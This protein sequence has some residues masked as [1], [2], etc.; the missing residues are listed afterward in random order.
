MPQA[1]KVFISF[2][3]DGDDHVDAVLA[4]ADWLRSHA[5]D[6][7]IDQYEESPPEGW[8]IW[9]QQQIE[10]A[11]FVLVVCTQAYKTRIEKNEEPGVGLGAIWEGQLIMMNLYKSQGRNSKYIPVMINPSDQAFI[12]PLLNSV[13]RYCV[14]T[15]D[16]Y[17]KLY[18]RLTAQHAIEK[19]PLGERQ[20]LPQ[21][22][23]RSRPIERRLDQASNVDIVSSTTFSFSHPGVPVN[24]VRHDNYLKTIAKT[25]TASNKIHVVAVEG[26]EGIGKTTLLGQFSRWKSD[27]CIS[28]F[29]EQ[30][31]R[32]TYDTDAMRLNI[33]RQA[34]WILNNE[35]FPQ[36]NISQEGFQEYLDR[37]HAVTRRRHAFTYF[38]LDGIDELMV[39]NAGAARRVVD[40]LP[41]PALGTS[42]YVVSGDAEELRSLFP[43]GVATK[44]FPLA[45][46]DLDETITLF[47]S[48][49][50]DLSA[51]KDLHGLCSGNPA[52]LSSARRMIVRGAKPTDLV[53]AISRVTSP[54]EVEWSV[55]ARG[56]EQI[57]RILAI[58]AFQ[59]RRSKLV[60]LTSSVGISR[61]ELREKLLSFSVI[62]VNSEDLVRFRADWFRKQAQKELHQFR[63]SVHKSIAQKL[64]SQS[65]AVDRVLDVSLHYAEAED[66]EHVLTFLSSDHLVELI[67]KA[68]S[69]NRVQNAVQLGLNAARHLERPGDQLRFGLDSAVLNEFF[70]FGYALSEVSALAAL[71]EYEAALGIARSAVMKED[72]LHLLA[73][74]ARSKAQNGDRP[75]PEL[76]EHLTALAAE[77][78]PKPLG[79][80]LSDICVELSAV[81]PDIALDLADRSQPNAADRDRLFA[82]LS[83][84]AFTVGESQ[85]STLFERMKAR[86]HKGHIDLMQNAL[87]AIAG[88]RSADDVLASARRLDKARDQ[89]FVL[90]A[91]LRSG[92]HIDDSGQII[93]YA[94]NAAITATDYTINATVLRELSE[95]LR[96][97]NDMSTSRRLIDIFGAQRGA[98]QKL[99]PTVD[100]VRLE[101]LLAETEARYDLPS[102]ETRI[103]TSYYEII[104]IVDVD[105]RTLSWAWL[106]AGLKRITSVIGPTSL[107]SLLSDAVGELEDSYLLLLDSTADH[108]QAATDIIVTIADWDVPKA[109]EFTSM[110]NTER[111]HDW[112]LLDVIE[113]IMSATA[114]PEAASFIR[115]VI[116]EIGDSELA[117]RGISEAMV[118]LSQN[119]TPTSSHLVHFSWLLQ[120]SRQIKDA[121]LRTRT[122]QAAY[123]VMCSR[124]EIDGRSL[125]ELAD[126]LLQS[127]TA[128]STAWFQV[129]DGFFIAQVLAAKAPE[130]AKEYVRR[131]QAVRREVGGLT[132][133]AAAAVYTHV[134]RLAIR[135]FSGLVRRS[136]T[137]MSDISLLAAQIDRLPSPGERAILW[138]EVAIKCACQGSAEMCREIVNERVRTVLAGISEAD[139]AYSAYVKARVS[140]AVFAS[141]TAAAYIVFTELN[142]TLRDYACF[143]TINFLLRNCLPTDPEEYLQGSGY[144]TTFT[145]LSQVC[146]V[147][148]HVSSDAFVFLVIERVVDSVTGRRN[149]A[150]LKQSQKEEIMR[151]L[152]ELAYSKFPSAKF[153]KHD[154]YKVI[155]K[156]QLNRFRFETP[157]EELVAEAHS[158]PNAADRGYVLFD[159]GL[160]VYKSDCG[161]GQSIIDSSLALIR[162]IPSRLE[163]ADRLV[164]F[165]DDL[166]LH[167]TV[168]SQNL[169]REARTTLQHSEKG[170]E[171]HSVRNLIDVAAKIGDE[172]AREL[173]SVL[174]DDHAKQMAQQRIELRSVKQQIIND[175]SVSDSVQG[176][177]PHEYSALGKM[178]LASL[179]SGRIDSIRVSSA[180]NF[181]DTLAHETLSR[182]YMLMTWIVENA[183]ERH[184][185][186]ERASIYLRPLFE[187]TIAS[188]ELAAKLAEEAFSR[189]RRK[190]SAPPS[191]SMIEAQTLVTRDQLIAY[192]KRWIGAVGGGETL[193]IVD[194][195]FTPS[196]LIFVR[197]IRSVDPGS[198]I[199]IVTS[200]NSQPSES[201]DL[202]Q[203]YAQHWRDQISEQKPP[204]TRIAFLDAANGRS[205]FP[206]TMMLTN[207][208]GVVL[209]SSLLR[210][211]VEQ[212]DSIR[213]LEPGEAGSIWESINSY[214]AGDVDEFEGSRVEYSL[215]R[216]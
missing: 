33:T 185:R 74:I 13:T 86:G 159:I 9:M 18:R 31:D 120:R 171:M 207:A 115:D 162:T 88:K 78:D 27:S 191:I 215:F 14:D 8:L 52:Y 141:D 192:L 206:R 65:D 136:L 172:F 118:E 51:L 111:R 196:D 81:L 178:L 61:D 164:Q 80:R 116:S 104:Q 57:E 76:L 154:G 208:A 94:L 126:D 26:V 213:E 2:S 62:A 163:R 72:R 97:I 182:S 24:E 91:W 148:Q 179:N 128:I 176:A 50:T 216:L 32:T 123:S 158:I 30:D 122:L 125:S 180:M 137:A 119:E 99:G 20:Q 211:G 145:K 46:F 49:M 53:K 205:P 70:R 108:Y 131:S 201:A 174:D 59:D 199:L 167:S 25:L 184:A 54:F 152:S 187:G 183:V 45:E 146:D 109:I 98:A 34:H 155:A 210:F 181:M 161:K 193:M 190:V 60:D 194:P 175:T 195:M 63:R 102:S 58:L 197:L 28:V 214:I 19:P 149:D 157:I 143:L 35:P 4:L 100:Y 110:V 168:L 209:S 85:S 75:E 48:I 71:K 127:W 106:I 83:A 165:A 202:K 150:R 204:N 90:R 95:G 103:L 132:S 134:V 124:S 23:R 92:N 156:I 1:P 3:H 166:R 189:D 77:I 21:R 16:G 186:D 36:S 84:T 188:A 107:D 96:H 200:R 22:N 39:H 139:S 117:D 40:L 169:L 55:Q 17:D 37:L 147:L 114:T 10:S 153:I 67:Q 129:E 64:L 43:T 135:A 11:Q 42:K 69:I 47:S 79:R 112:I 101:V 173:A 89:L 73:I 151:R 142:P 177:S 7:S 56:D 198:R 44:S 138:A 121:R 144:E 82:R 87:S 130:M 93:D 29:I 15:E 160:F 68:Q 6:A 203:L 133:R 113:R 212:P 12:P 105:V 38:V 170:D 140:P 41:Q 66:H 5:V